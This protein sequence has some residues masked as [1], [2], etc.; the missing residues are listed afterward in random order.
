MMQETKI[1]LYI[2]KH[3]ELETRIT[4]Q[5]LQHQSTDLKCPASL[6]KI[7]ALVSK[8]LFIYVFFSVFAFSSAPD[9]IHPPFPQVVFL[10]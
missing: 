6:N 5:L 10:S 8:L 1:I 7:R 4:I 3:E 9:L 2:S